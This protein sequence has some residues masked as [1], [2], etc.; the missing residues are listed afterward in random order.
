MFLNVEILTKTDDGDEDLK[1]SGNLNNT[2]ADSFWSTK[3]ES[4][5]S[6]EIKKSNF[7][8]FFITIEQEAITHY[9]QP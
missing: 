8:R 4:S 6:S 1:A 2:N 3:D 5:S 7:K 9:N